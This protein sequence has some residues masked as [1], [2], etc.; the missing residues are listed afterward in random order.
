MYQVPQGSRYSVAF[1]ADERENPHRINRMMQDAQRDLGDA[2]IDCM[3]PD[4][5]Y[6]VR[7]QRAAFPTLTYCIEHRLTFELNE[8]RTEHIVVTR[9]DEM[10]LGRL[11][12]TAIDEL[13]YRWRARFSSWR[14]FAD[15]LERAQGWT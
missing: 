1:Y 14:R 13:R 12:I 15:W 7:W 9:Y 6:A 4:Q 3:K 10:P 5:W 11:A 8:A 2:L